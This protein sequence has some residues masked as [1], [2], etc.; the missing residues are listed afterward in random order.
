MQVG[1]EFPWLNQVRRMYQVPGQHL[2]IC[3]RGCGKL[4]QGHGDE[5]FRG[6]RT[7]AFKTQ[8]DELV[9]V[10]VTPT[11]FI[12]PMNITLLEGSE[13]VCTLLWLR[14]DL[15]IWRRKTESP[16]RLSPCNWK[17]VGVLELED[18]WLDLPS[19]TM[20]SKSKTCGVSFHSVWMIGSHKRLVSQVFKCQC[21]VEWI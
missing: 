17:G 8:W 6:N 12:C 14:Q 7:S 1:E 5:S 4:G 13:W 15:P 18:R 3:R 9:C 2:L 11:P 20:M 21:C 10:P 19:F 16:W